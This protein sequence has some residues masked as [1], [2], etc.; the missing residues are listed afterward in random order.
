MVRVMMLVYY[1]AGISCSVTQYSDDNNDSNNI[2]NINIIVVEYHMVRRRPE[3][4]GNFCTSS[5]F[6][7]PQHARLPGGA[8][9][10]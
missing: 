10:L 3:L 6:I 8:P 7:I 9:G 4:P 2:V 1:N 5:F